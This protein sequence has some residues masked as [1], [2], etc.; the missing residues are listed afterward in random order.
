[1]PGWLNVWEA[2]WPFF[3]VPVSNDL[4]EAVAVWALGPLFVQVIVLPAGTVMVLGA[5]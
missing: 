4:L 1:V 2:L 5:N 3:N